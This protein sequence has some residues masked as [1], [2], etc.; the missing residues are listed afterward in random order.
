[1]NWKELQEKMIG[2]RRD[3][4]SFPEAGWTEFRTC[5]KIADNLHALGYRVL[6]GPEII[7][8][9]SVMGRQEAVIPSHQERALEQ[10]ASRK[11]IERMN[12]LTGVVGIL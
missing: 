11:W 5:S 7:E 10:G 4:H 12:G 8:L 6:L 1:M 2:Y 9:S 3:F